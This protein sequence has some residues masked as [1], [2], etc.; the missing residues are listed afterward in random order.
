MGWLKS[1]LQVE[2][3]DFDS[4]FATNIKA[5]INVTQIA[6]K[7]MLNRNVPGAI[8]NLSSQA[9]LVGLLDHSVYCS[10]K[11][12]VD[13]FT[14]AIALEFGPKRIRINA[15]NP[16]VILTEMGKLGWSDPKIS[17]PM[18]EKIPLKRFG[19]V[20]EVVNAV[21]FLLSDQASM[22][23]GTTLPIDGGYTAV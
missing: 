3:A 21:L 17:K 16:T 9:S 2:E 11:G 22:I 10:S 1:F 12:A 4:V 23:T 6:I 20:E 13:S 18:I 8:V 19:K 5:L 7:N 15:V 14:R